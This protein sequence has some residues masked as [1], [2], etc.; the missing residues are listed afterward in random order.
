MR[1]TVIL[2]RL[3]PLPP[4]SFFIEIEVKMYTFNN[5]PVFERYSR[6]CVWCGDR[7]AY[8]RGAFWARGALES[9]SGSGRPLTIT[10]CLQSICSPALI[11]SIIS[12]PPLHN[13]HTSSL[14]IRLYCGSNNRSKKL[15]FCKP[16]NLKSFY[17]LEVKRCSFIIMIKV[18]TNYDEIPYL[19]WWDPYLVQ[20]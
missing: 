2:V 10:P 3:P 18:W 1:V 6:V 16:I 15:A 4:H 5:I 7:T 19:C 20:S 13:P 14:S 11:S 9:P 12:K 8:I 17:L